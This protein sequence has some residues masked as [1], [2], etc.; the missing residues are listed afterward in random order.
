MNKES[1]CGNCK[2]GRMMNMPELQNQL[3]TT[4]IL[5]P[6]VMFPLGTPKGVQLMPTR[7]IVSPDDICGQWKAVDIH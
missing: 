3:V 5:N 7:P 4:C 2:F 1:K 6:P